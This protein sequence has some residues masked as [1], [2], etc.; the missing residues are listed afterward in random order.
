MIR[1]VNFYLLFISIFTII[2][3]GVRALYECDLKK[4]IALSTLS[5]LGLIMIILRI[6]FNLLGFYHLMTHA[7]FKSLLFLCAGIVIHLINNNQDIRC[8]G[9][10]NETIPFVSVVFYVSILSIIGCPFLAGFYSKDLI[11]ELSYI[12]DV[13]LFLFIIIVISLSLTVI[14]SLR[15]FFYLF[16]S[17]TMNFMS[18]RRFYGNKLINFSIILLVILSMVSGSLLN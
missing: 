12:L 13:N 5:Q 3:S 1:G 6:G 17:K 10:L 14:Y 15:L 8:C 18:V 11:M 16:F 9:G 4:I 7:I 2:M